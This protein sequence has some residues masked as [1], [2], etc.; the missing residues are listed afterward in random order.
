MDL[1]EYAQSRASSKQQEELKTIVS[2]E[3]SEKAPAEDE[4]TPLQDMP[5]LQDTPPIRHQ[6]FIDYAK[7]LTKKDLAELIAAV[8]ALS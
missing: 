7:S 8:I 6:S 5:P 1:F 2:L 3:V 4:A